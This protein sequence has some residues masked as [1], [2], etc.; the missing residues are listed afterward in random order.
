MKRVIIVGRGAS[1]KSTLARRLSEISQLPMTELDKIF[2]QPGLL[3]T[4]R[5]Q[6]IVIQEKLAAEPEWIMDG[7][8]GPYDALE[9]RLRRADTIIFLDFSLVRCVWRAI[10]RSRER[11]DFWHWVI[12]Y[13]RKYRRQLLATISQHA[14]NVNLMIFSS[15]RDIQGFLDGITK[16]R[17]E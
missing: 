1:G 16:H 12:S 4:P 14:P 2:W 13:R 6:W 3:A 5:K 10:R 17:P 9:A 8:F 11:L 7:D 15:P